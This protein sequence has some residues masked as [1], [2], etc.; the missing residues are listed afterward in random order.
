MWSA[1]C[2]L[3]ETEH[4]VRVDKT[5]FWLGRHPGLCLTRDQVKPLPFP[6]ALICLLH[7]KES[8]TTKSYVYSSNP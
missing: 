8:Q 3:W 5:A 2:F 7:M 6:T 1:V 4:L